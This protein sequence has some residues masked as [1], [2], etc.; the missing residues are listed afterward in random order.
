MLSYEEAVSY[1][2]HASLFGGKKHGLENMKQLLAHLGN[3]EAHLRFVHVAGTNGKGSVCAY[4]ESMLRAAGYRTGLYTS[5]YLECFAERIRVDFIPICRQDLTRVA[6]QVIAAGRAMAAEGLSHPTFFELVTACAFLHFAQAKVDIVVA[7]VGLGGR[8]DATNVITPLCCA[9]TSIDLDHTKV[10]GNTKEEIA[11]EKAGIMKSG[12]PCVLSPALDD[13]IAAYLA[14][15]AARRGVPV[16]DASRCVMDELANGLDG[17]V[18]SLHGELNH[19]RL[20]TRLLGA[21]QRNNLLTALLVADELRRQGLALCDDAVQCGVAA[22][23]WPGRMEVYRRA[24]LILIDGAHN[25]QGAASLAQAMAHYLPGQ[26]ARLLTGV[27]SGKDYQGIAAQLASFAGEVYI[28][29]PESDR[30]L[31]GEILQQ[32]Y[33]QRHIRC[34]LFAT[35]DDA[36]HRALRDEEPL[37]IAGSLYLAGQARTRL[38]KLIG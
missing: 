26:K 6:N 30:A 32:A 19:P 18:L 31:P 9:V 33:L 38:A 5:P 36:L 12:V 7:E 4:V 13:G 27:L 29:K 35:L 14:A 8:L 15:L 28:T 11:F 37:V 17:Q 3:P 10:L 23:C 16:R 1:L 2:E 21:H 20:S 24:P 34:T 22:T 25:P